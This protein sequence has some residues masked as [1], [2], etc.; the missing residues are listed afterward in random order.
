MVIEREVKR[1]QRREKK[2]VL[3][4]K[5][6][7]RERELWFVKDEVIEEIDVVFFFFAGWIVFIL[8]RIGWVRS[9]TCFPFSRCFCC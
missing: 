4:G 7:R 9:G 1:E 8:C 5:L 6:N 2:K 3:E